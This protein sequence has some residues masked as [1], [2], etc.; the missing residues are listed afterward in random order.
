MA[1]LGLNTDEKRSR[2]LYLK[3]KDG[4]VPQDEGYGDVVKTCPDCNE[5]NHVFVL[6]LDHKTWMNGA[7]VQNAFPYL[8][9]DEREIL[10]SGM[11]GKCYD[12]MCRA[13]EQE[14]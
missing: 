2:A 10:I 1:E 6:T 4:E 9:A 5:E 11:C 12:K 13:W 3:Y 14:D 7:Y 8:S